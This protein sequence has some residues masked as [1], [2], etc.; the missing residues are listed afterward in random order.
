[1]TPEERAHFT[2]IKVAFEASQTADKSQRCF[3][4]GDCLTCENCWTLCPDNA[5]MK[6][7]EVASDDSPYVLDYDYCNGCGMCD[8]ECPT[9][10]IIMEPDH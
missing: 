1:M 8:D 9:G 2:E 7:V 4:C 5:V 6:T 3:S 10:Y